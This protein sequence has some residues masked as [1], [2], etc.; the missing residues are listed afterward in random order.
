[1]VHCRPSRACNQKAQQV[2]SSRTSDVPGTSVGWVVILHQIYRVARSPTASCVV[3]WLVRSTGPAGWVVILPYSGTRVHPDL[4]C[5]K[6]THASWL[7]F[8]W[9]VVPVQV[10]VLA[11]L[12]FCSIVA[13]AFTQIYRV[14][15]DARFMSWDLIGWVKMWKWPHVLRQDSFALF[16]RYSH[17]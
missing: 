11:G 8:D 4:S 15:A 5:R 13:L 12:A 1:M 6:V 10:P 16:L 14:A 3:I 17:K 9:F 2:N 7:C